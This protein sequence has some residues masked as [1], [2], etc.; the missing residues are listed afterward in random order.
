MTNN[1]TDLKTSFKQLSTEAREFYLT[2]QVPVL[3]TPPSGLE[4]LRD[5]VS[6]NRPVV[7]QNA[8]KQWPALNKWTTEYLVEKLRG[9]QISVA[10]TPTG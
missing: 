5:W 1:E 7:I 6:F 9:R 2:A 3:E 10:V 8:T 4:F